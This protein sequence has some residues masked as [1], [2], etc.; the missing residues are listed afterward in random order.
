MK[1]TKM[2]VDLVD[3]HFIV[4]IIRYEISFALNF[5]FTMDAISFSLDYIYNFT[6]DLAGG[7]C[8]S[9]VINHDSEFFNR[10][11]NNRLNFRRQTS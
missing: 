7:V 9:N 5:Q 1:R 6:N 2:E 4:T 8:C 3:K 11:A 10:K